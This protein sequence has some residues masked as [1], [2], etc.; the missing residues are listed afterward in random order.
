LGGFD[1]M[2][3]VLRW[4][5]KHSNFDVCSFDVFDTLLRRRIDPPELV[6]RLAAEHVSVML[7][8]SGIE[9]SADT[10]MKERS[11]V[12]E[13][14][15]RE[16]ALMGKDPVCHL[17]DVVSGVLNRL[18]ADS[19]VDGNDM[20]SYEMDLEKKATEPMPGVQAVLAYLRSRN[21]R[22]ICVSDTYLSGNQLASL[23]EHH[24]LLQ[25]IGNIYV[26]SDLGRRKSTSRLFRHVVENE[27]SSIVH[28]GDD[29]SLDR[30][31]P[32]RL[33]IKTLWFHSGSE[34]RRKRRLR[35]LLSSGDK[36]SY[37]NAVVGR[38]DRGDNPQ[39]CL[40]YDVLGP[41]LAVFVH[42]VAERAKKDDVETLFFV[43]RD[44][45]VMKKIYGI[46]QRGIFAD[47]GS[48]E[49][50]YLCLS[51]VTVRSAS[52]NRLTLADVLEV[53][54]YVVRFGRT[55]MALAGILRGYGLE[56]AD[57]DGVARRHQI[58][59]DA[60]IDDPIHNPK[61]GKL[62]ESDDFQEVFRSR[63]GALKTLLR[64]Y[65]V[66][67]GFMG[68]RNV[69][70]VDA[71]AEGVSQS[72][73]ERAFGGE[74]GY[75]VVHGYYF[76]LVD[77]GVKKSSF[78]L[79]LAQAKGI[80]SDWRDNPGNEQRAYGL[81]GL[82]IELFGHPNHGVAVGYRKRDSRVVPEFRRTP[83]EGQY[84]TTSKALD[85]ALDY[86][87]DYSTYYCLHGYDCAELLEQVKRSIRRWVA[88]A[89]RRDAEALRGLFLTG[90][91]PY[92]FNFGLVG[93]VTVKDVLT[94]RGLLGK[95][96]SSAWPEGTL[97]LA[98]APCLRW[99]L[100]TAGLAARLGEVD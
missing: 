34:Q 61:L 73:L 50:K 51:R 3:G 74:E 49:G 22:V 46:L 98:R 58:D 97:S 44:G 19:L 82:L 60:R 79:N 96:A 59:I 92:E 48:P 37:V 23:L 64:E 63:G 15:Q 71:N 1:G 90:D 12:E 24:G 83:Q 25:Y 93:N 85:G 76:N 5:R 9:V 11:A 72:L 67:I 36:M 26:S 66:G 27:G 89:P 21:I 69:A 62:L 84:R 45:Y 100:Y 40:G 77:L 7:A 2:G 56:P 55:D 18:N 78:S 81:V 30:D 39:Y 28:I 16:A 8:R 86:A 20:V 17:H 52:L 13:S 42:N 70:V 65:L 10:V 47:G 35:K 38:V 41:A 32:R 54:G 53:C 31:L 91:W 43:A 87:R 95:A 88:V 29:Y 99:L 57:Y 80:V 68:G 33:G 6:K 14:L 75:P 4:L 94:T